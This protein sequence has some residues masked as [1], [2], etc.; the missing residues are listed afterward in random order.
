MSK[1]CNEPFIEPWVD[2]SGWDD[3]DLS[4]IKTPAFIVDEEKL[5]KNL[6]ILK[7]VSD[8]TG[9]KIL[10][11]LKGFSMFSVFPLMREYLSGSEASSV[12][13]AHLGYEKFGK[14]THVFSPSYSKEN[15]K[16]YIKYAD[17][18]V[19]NS[20]SEWDRL[21]ETILKSNKRISCG[22]RVNLEHSEIENEMYDPSRK[23]SHF[24]VTI[25]NFEGQDL[26]GLEGLHFHNLCE[27]DAD[28]L[29][30]S[31]VV[32]QD[33]FGKY[34]EG[35]KWVNF[36]GGHH[37]TRTGYNIRLLV[38]IIKD[39]KEKYPHLDVY[40]EPGEAIALNAGILVG[41][42]V[43]IFNNGINIAVLD[44][45]ATCHMPDVIEG[46]YLPTVIGANGAKEG[47]ENIYKIVGPSCLAG[48][49]IGD[50]SFDKPLSVGQKIVFLN[51]AIYTMVK[52]NTFNGIDLPSIMLRK[53][54]GKL[55]TIKTFNYKDFKNRLS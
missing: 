30:R 9:C 4:K 39:F 50:Y 36:G 38:R 28:A 52:T 8:E 37:I 25:K 27:L 6:E 22:M 41:E 53:N 21:K 29:E 1:Q 26:N 7:S 13:E 5:K 48:D 18:L 45:S 49:V 19:F 43:D 33:K 40:L 24:G 17:H 32:F 3:L 35:M 44:V 2:R 55:K 42:V 12:N 47:D 11:A 16:D 54:D 23:N 20:F 31:L 10:A 51:M 46:P 14:E 15:I 34:L